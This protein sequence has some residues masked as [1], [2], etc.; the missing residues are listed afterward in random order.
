MR[1]EK[2]KA[3][4]ELLYAQQVLVDTLK[5]SE[6]ELEQRVT[7]RTDE[8]QQLNRKLETLSLTDSLTGIANRR[9]FDTILRQECKRA[10]RLGHPLALAMLDVD[11][12]KA[13]NDQYGHPSGD[14][15]LQQIAQVLSA[16]VCRSSDLVARY[17]GEEFVFI[18]P[19]LNAA[20]ALDIAEKVVRT[21]A[22][23]ALPHS[24]SP[25]GHVTVSM[26]VAAITPGT[27]NSAAVLL[28]CADA[29]LYLAKTQ[30]RNRA[31]LGVD[32]AVSVVCKA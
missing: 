32:Q 15:C 14:A 22:D 8:L 23:L 9:H 21:V 6:R 4:A 31:E 2:T 7:Q 20:E 25:V 24:Q 10:Q 19:M 29:A 30:G 26:G 3:Q 18:A 1:R 11:W 17:G 27:E 5:T 28:Q 12:F 13:Y 16:T